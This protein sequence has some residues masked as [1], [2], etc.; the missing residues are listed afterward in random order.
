MLGFNDSEKTYPSEYGSDTVHLIKLMLE[1]RIMPISE[2]SQPVTAIN[3][4]KDKAND[5]VIRPDINEVVV[6][7]TEMK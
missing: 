4:K 5:I 7:L 1:K 3:S 6:R 2:M